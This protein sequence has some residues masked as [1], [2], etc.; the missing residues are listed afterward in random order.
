MTM[1]VTH[2]WSWS[3]EFTKAKDE[4]GGGMF[5]LITQRFVTSRKEGIPFFIVGI[6]G[7]ELW[8]LEGG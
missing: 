2:D 4:N 7:P 1:R 8:Y 5:F 6:A 3:E